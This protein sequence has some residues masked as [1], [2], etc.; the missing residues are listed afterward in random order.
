[1]TPGDREAALNNAKAA[2]SSTA[3]L[4]KLLDLKAPDI[5][6]ERERQLAVRRLQAIP[7]DPDVVRDATE[8]FL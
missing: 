5:I 4:I 3:R 2:L 1:M 7:M 8:S 6:I